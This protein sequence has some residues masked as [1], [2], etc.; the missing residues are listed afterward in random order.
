V[1]GDL[2]AGAALA[3]LVISAAAVVAAVLALAV[4]RRPGL[5]LSVFLDLLLAAGLL[6]LAGDPDWQ[7]IATAA[8][9]VAIRRLLGLGLRIGDRSLTFTAR[10]GWA[11]DR[12]RV[13]IHRLLH[14]AWRD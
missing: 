14:P 8:A 1:T 5:A 10:T 6:R 11:P 9:I 3:G 13:A 4:S 12:R 7:A 2:E